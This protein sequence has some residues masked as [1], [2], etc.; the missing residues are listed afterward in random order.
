MAAGDTCVSSVVVVVILQAWLRFKPPQKYAAK[1][2]GPPPPLLCDPSRVVVPCGGDFFMA[3][4]QG[5]AS[6]QRLRALALQLRPS[7]LLWLPPR[8]LGQPRIAQIPA[9]GPGPR[10]ARFAGPPAQQSRGNTGE[11]LCGRCDY[12][13]LRRSDS[14]ADSAASASV[15]RTFTC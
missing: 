15:R 6:L 9:P 2:A 10:I 12:R 4:L 1:P 7:G 14:D 13:L 3:P 8:S 11:T 5:T